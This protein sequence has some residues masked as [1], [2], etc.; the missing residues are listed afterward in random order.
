MSSFFFFC[1]L[2][3]KNR[4][5]KKS[6]LLFLYCEHSNSSARPQQP[7]T[8]GEITLRFVPSSFFE[9]NTFSSL[10]ALSGVLSA[11]SD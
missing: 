1:L 7:S 10:R 5:L 9:E 2:K 11:L 3:K 4:N 8:V 6:R